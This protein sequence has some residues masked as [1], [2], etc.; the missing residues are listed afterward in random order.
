M[1]EQLS[2]PTLPY[3]VSHIYLSAQQAPSART[4]CLPDIHWYSLIAYFPL[5][6]KIHNNYSSVPTRLIVLFRPNLRELLTSGLSA[7]PQ[8]AGQGGFAEFELGYQNQSTMFK[9]PQLESDWLWRL[10]EASTTFGKPSQGFP[11]VLGIFPKPLE[12][13]SRKPKHSLGFL[14]GHRVATIV[15]YKYEALPLSNI[16]SFT[17]SYSLDPRTNLRLSA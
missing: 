8:S 6:L 12:S 17:N 16:I 3:P 10:A 13:S 15:L 14:H 2:A 4:K 5:S 1:I 11:Q 7:K 9:P